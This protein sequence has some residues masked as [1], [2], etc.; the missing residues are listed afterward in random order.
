MANTKS[1]SPISSNLASCRPQTWVW[2]A[3]R[4]GWPMAPHVTSVHFAWY[5][6]DSLV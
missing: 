4:Q 6:H 5:F 1:L 3:T 2:H